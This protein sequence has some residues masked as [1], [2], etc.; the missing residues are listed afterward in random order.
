MTKL[1]LFL[2]AADALDSISTFCSAFGAIAVVG[3]N[4][5]NEAE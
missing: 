2:Y 5:Q 3:A 4:K 1:S